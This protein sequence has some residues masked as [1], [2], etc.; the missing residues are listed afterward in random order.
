MPQSDSANWDPAVEVANAQGRG[1]ALILCEHATNYMPPAYG[2][3]GLSPQ[4][5]ISHAA[6]DPG[7]RAVAL[8]LSAALDAPMVAS[9]LSRLIYDCNRP[10]E[11]ASAMP[12]KSELIEVPG[13]RNLTGA[14]RQ[15]RT[16]QVYV[17]FCSTVSQIIARRQAEGLATALITMHSFTPVYFGQSRAV[18]IGILHD[19]D[20]RLADAMLAQAPLL[21][22]RA[23]RRNEPYGPADGVTHSLQLHGLRHGLANVMIEVRNDLR[24]TAD[25]ETRIAQEL[26]QLLR[27]G[28]AALSQAEAPDA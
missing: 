21:P 4:D 20:S 13:N 10:P 19:T 5:Q 1:A 2:S 9:R 7:A 24:Q 16:D 12:E 3:L 11:A 15:A 26:L 6:W 27:P 8:Q 28:L 18:E 14:Q 22:H 17:P 23:I 25:Q